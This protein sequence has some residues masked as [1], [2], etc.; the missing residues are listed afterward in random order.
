M[1]NKKHPNQS[2]P[3]TEG[4][5]LFKSTADYGYQ[6]SGAREKLGDIAA[7]A[8]EMIPGFPENVTP[9]TKSEVYAGFMLRYQE[10]NPAK[11][12]KREGTDT[13]IPL[14]GDIPQ[15]AETLKMTV[16]YANAVSGQ[17]FGKLRASQPNLYGLIKAVRE[18]SRNYA[19][20]CW[21]N[22]VAAYK[23]RSAEG[24]TGRS[25][26]ATKDWKVRVSDFF[27]TMKKGRKTALA[28]GDATVPSE[29]KFKAATDAFWAA[30]K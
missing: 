15:M 8:P 26:G 28:R 2:S 23:T 14:E 29:E 4:S 5:Y 3:T 6:F 1:A 25:R 12:Y 22:L 30:L 10:K 17:E 9:E 11:T 27:D 13:Y 19:A 24:S 7:R 18:S 20:A 21:S 16:A